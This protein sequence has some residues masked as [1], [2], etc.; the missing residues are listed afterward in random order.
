MGIILLFTGCNFGDKADLSQSKAMLKAPEPNDDYFQEIGEAVGLDFVHSI[1]AA[2]MENIIESVGGGAAFLDY[3]QDGFMDIF[4]CNGTWVEGFSNTKPKESNL[5]NHLYKN[6]QNGTFKEVSREAGVDGPLYSM[7]I[8]VGDVD[9]DGFPDI[10][11][12]NYGTNTLYH[13][14]GDGTFKD[15][16]DTAGVE[17]GKKCSVGAV[18]LD[19]DND[20]LLD[21]YVGNYLNYDPDYSYYYAPDGFPGPLA[22][23]S[24]K[25]LLYQNKGN[26]T[27]EDVTE[28]MGIVDIDGRAMGVGAADYDDDGFVDIY[29]ANDHTAN[30]LWHN[31]QGKGF[32]DKG[33]LS[34][35]GFSQAGEATVSMS[36]DFA[37]YNHDELLDIFISDD[38]YCL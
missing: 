37:D 28:Q 8:T 32:T 11:L 4:V 15:I 33:T 2:E 17:G 31:E 38:N 20:G 9:N 30:Y 12:S 24:Q 13:N 1:G 29:V 19:Y 21:L 3:D 10:F 5:H 6:L 22:Y 18:W 35:T 16:A 36:V 14:K 34:G 26:G 23:D 7:G 27:F 25:D